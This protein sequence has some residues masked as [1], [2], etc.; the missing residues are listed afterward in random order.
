MKFYVQKSDIVEH[1][2][3]LISVVPGKNAL[4]ILVNYLIKADEEKGLLTFVVSNLELIV[5]CSVE[6]R[7]IEGGITA[8]NA[9]HF[10]DIINSLPNDTEIAFFT[11]DNGK[12]NIVAGHAKFNLIMSQPEFFPAVPPIKEENKISLQADL[13]KTMVDKTVFATSTDKSKPV[14]TGV[15]WKITENKQEMVATDGKKLARA[16][17]KLSDAEASEND[18]TQKE[19]IVPAK[20]FNFVKKIIVEQDDL[21]AYFEKTRIA[22]TY[23]NYTVFTTLIISRYPKYERV[24]PQDND[25]ILIID[26]SV[27]IE[28]IKRA[29]LL[30]SELFS[31]VTLDISKTML[32]VSSED[33][34]EGE[35]REQLTDFEYEGEDLRIAFNFRYLTNILS[36]I[37]TQK[38]KI[39]FKDN[40]VPALF[41]NYPEDESNLSFLLLLMPLGLK[42][43]DN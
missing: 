39:T 35:A 17:L 14:Y 10:N 15:Y 5:T 18:E 1:I 7:I 43:V 20:T 11:D 42:D 29:S 19:Y 30:S 37:D 28:A 38:V 34:E 32:L 31:L 40:D 33:E 26:K 27:F 24:I 16:I 3:N 41:H 4:P 6:A 9:K 36:L 21:T 12:F 25:K 23:K 8:I 13:F 22:F 2:Q